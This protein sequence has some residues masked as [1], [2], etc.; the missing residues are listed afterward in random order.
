[1]PGHSQAD[2]D[3][4]RHKSKVN[5]AKRVKRNKWR[6]HK[7]ESSEQIENADESKNVEE[8]SNGDTCY[9]CLEVHPRE[10]ELV[11]P[12]GCKKG[13]TEGRGMPQHFSCLVHQIVSSGDKACALCGLRFQDPRIKRGLS[14]WL[15]FRIMD[16]A[17]M[18]IALTIALCCAIV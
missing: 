8:S 15:W 4:R 2:Q 10:P 6:Q 5:R 9:V 18:S 11:W 3:R 7:G 16:F 1:M 17:L 13:G 14:R 12:C